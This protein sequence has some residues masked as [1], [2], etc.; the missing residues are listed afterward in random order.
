MK[1]YGYGLARGCGGIAEASARD[2]L[3][4]RK[5]LSP[6]GKFLPHL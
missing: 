4:D 1:K 5:N 3:F 6:I 2:F